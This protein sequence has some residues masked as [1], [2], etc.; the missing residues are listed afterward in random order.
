MKIKP[1]EYG[2]Q[3]L[4]VAVNTK[5]R[6][7]DYRYG[8]YFYV[9]VRAICTS[10]QVI[11]SVHMYKF[12]VILILPDTAWHVIEHWD[13]RGIKKLRFEEISDLE[14]FAEDFR[15]MELDDCSEHSG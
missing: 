1:G 6:G 14:F 9:K 3:N 15:P 8:E 10:P 7:E 2:E 13:D 12:T 11:G 5:W 4:A